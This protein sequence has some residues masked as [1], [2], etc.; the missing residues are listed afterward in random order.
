MTTHSIEAVAETYSSWLNRASQ[1]PHEAFRFAKFRFAK[2]LQ[3]AAQLAMCRNPAEALALQ[4]H[5]VSDL[6]ADYLAESQKIA[7]LVAQLG[8]GGFCESQQDPRNGQQ[9]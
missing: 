3:A 1:V 5:I 7:E 9:A 8:Q 6:A 2:D 4:A